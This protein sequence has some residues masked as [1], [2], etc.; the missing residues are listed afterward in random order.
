[1]QRLTTCAVAIAVLAMAGTCNAGLA[2][3]DP[4]GGWDYTFDGD[5]ALAGPT[6]SFD[7][8]DGTWD[9]DNGSDQWDGSAVGAGRPGGASAITEGVSIPGDLDYLRLQNNGEVGAYGMGAPGST[10][11]IMFGLSIIDGT[12]AA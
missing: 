7:S 9:H 2:Y 1:M 6:G 12:G 10:R 3:S 5:A 11:S 4:A 8:L